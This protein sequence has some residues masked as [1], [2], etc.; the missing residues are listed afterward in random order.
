LGG[1]APVARDGGGRKG[2]TQAT[3]NRRYLNSKRDWNLAAAPASAFA[4]AAKQRARCL[5]A[6]MAQ[7]WARAPLLPR[8][9]H[10]RNPNFGHRHRAGDCCSSMV[11]FS[12]TESIAISGAV[13]AE[14]RRLWLLG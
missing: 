1:L 8:E 7:L 11:D 13:P 3:V 5:W 10:V 2:V 9:R 12:L 6:R 14:V 4:G